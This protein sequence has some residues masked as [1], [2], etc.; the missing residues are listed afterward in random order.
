MSKEKENGSFSVNCANELEL[1][2]EHGFGGLVLVCL[3]LLLCIGW[4]QKCEN[5]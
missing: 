4:L 2:M 1:Q 5:N 3:H